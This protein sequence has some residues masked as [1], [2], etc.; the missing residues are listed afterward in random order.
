[1]GKLFEKYRGKSFPGPA[2][3]IVQ[4]EPYS[5]PDQKTDENDTIGVEGT[6]KYFG[7]LAVD[8]ES[9]E[10]LVPMEIVQAPTLGEITKDGFVDGWKTI[11]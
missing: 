7:D 11:G 10:C 2:L 9:V 8:L 1:L 5:I 4:L 6:M 3:R